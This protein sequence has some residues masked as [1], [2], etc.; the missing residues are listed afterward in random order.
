M[1]DMTLLCPD[2]FKD[3]G[4]QRRIADVRKEHG[5]GRCDF[6]PR[7]KGIPLEIVAE[8]V[9][10]VFRNNFD[11]GDATPVFSNDPDDPEVYYAHSGEDLWDTVRNLTSPS[12]DDIL[13]LVIDQLKATDGYWPNDGDFEFY[14]DQAKYERIDAGDNS[15]RYLW[16]SF[17]EIIVHGQRFFNKQA[18]DFLA[19]MF[20]RIHVQRDISKNSPVHLLVPGEISPVHRARIATDKEIRDVRDDPATQLGAPPRKLGKPNRMNPSGIPAFYASMDFPTCVAELR[21]RVGC[22]VVGGEFKICRPILALDTTRFHA[23]P[24]EVNLFSKDHT[25]RLTQWRFMQFFMKE[26]AKPISP[27]DEHL[28]YVPTQVVA[29]YLNKIFSCYIDGS[30]RNI[31]AIIY[32][33]AQRP[34]G[35]NI[36]FLGNAALTEASKKEQPAR[37]SPS[38]SS[39]ERAATELAK[40]RSP[41]L[42]LV[43]GSLKVAK[44]TEA[45]FGVSE[46]Q[47]PDTHLDPP[48]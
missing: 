37:A 5:E 20:K 21:P 44:V 47:S 25:R 15:S 45:S 12:S 28:E 4:L 29:E 11:F 24:K 13:E 14:N 48:F 6:H 30:K 9:D 10:E 36:V 46:A 41:G 23:P 40:E 32:Q 18:E 7:R 3:S 42:A 8:I 1:P 16:D 22:N 27:E 33:S 39:F 17:C 2:C 31:E 34:M 26:I 38:M 35:K 43:V 19:D